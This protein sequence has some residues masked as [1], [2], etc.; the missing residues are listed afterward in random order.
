MQGMILAFDKAL[1][2]YRLASRTS[3]GLIMQFWRGVLLA[4]SMYTYIY[5]NKPSD[6]DRDWAYIDTHGQRNAEG[7]WRLQYGD[8]AT[9]RARVPNDWLVLLHACTLL[10]RWHHLSHP[11]SSHVSTTARHRQARSQHARTEGEEG[12]RLVSVILSMLHLHDDDS[13]DP[14]RISELGVTRLPSR[15]VARVIR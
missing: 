10:L 7:S 14:P 4:C 3:L 6:W 12:S 13:L 5:N 8:R 15:C 11:C 9:G 1:R 2:G